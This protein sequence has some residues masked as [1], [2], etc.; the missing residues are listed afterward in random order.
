MTITI[1]L[2]TGHAAFDEGGREQEIARIL[3]E[4]IGKVAPF[5]SGAAAKLYDVNGNAVGTITVR[6][7]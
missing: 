7:K 5:Q 6:G 2:N 4:A 3:R 1:R